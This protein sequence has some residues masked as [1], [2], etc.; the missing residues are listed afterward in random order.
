MPGCNYIAFWNEP[1]MYHSYSWWYHWISIEL[2]FTKCTAIEMKVIMVLSNVKL[3]CRDMDVIKNT[4]APRSAAYKKSWTSP[5][6]GD[7]SIWMKIVEWDIKLHTNSNESQTEVSYMYF[8]GN[9]KRQSG[10]NLNLLYCALMF[11][12][13]YH[14]SKFNWDYSWT[15]IISNTME[16]SKWFE[17][18]NHVILCVF[19]WYLESYDI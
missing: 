10:G 18:P 8:Q 14:L 17:S 11:Y 12:N 16:M 4:W 7:T 3:L 2:Y 19:S 6:A 15:L 9:K 5:T 13:T 1:V